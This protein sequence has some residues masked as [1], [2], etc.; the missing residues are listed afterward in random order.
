MEKAADIDIKSYTSHGVEAVG[1]L[2]M[3]ERFWNV[4]ENK[5]PVAEL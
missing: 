5:G 2:K 1:T 3:K 4:Y